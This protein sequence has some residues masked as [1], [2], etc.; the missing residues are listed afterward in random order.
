MG[1]QGKKVYRS[2]GGKTTSG[3]TSTDIRGKWEFSEKERRKNGKEPRKSKKRRKGKLFCN[4]KGG[5]VGKRAVER[6]TGTSAGLQP[7]EAFCRG[8]ENGNN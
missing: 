7:K 1:K 4:W 5:R 2:W 3:D 8:K 6:K